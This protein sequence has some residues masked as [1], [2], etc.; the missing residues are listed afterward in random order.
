MLKETEETI[1]FF[2]TFLSLAAIQLGGGAGP[3]G[4][5]GYAYD[6]HSSS[7]EPTNF[8]GAQ[9]SLGAQAVIW[10][11]TAPKCPPWRRAY[12]VVQKFLSCLSLVARDSP[13]LKGFQILLYT[14]C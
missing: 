2:V 9:S 7:P 8:F 13:V 11:G 3:L 10:G 12:F 6:K 14:N 4:P 1:V 5:P